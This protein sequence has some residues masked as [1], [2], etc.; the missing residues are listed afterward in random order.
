M[1]NSFEKNMTSKFEKTHHQKNQKPKT[2][3]S[4]EETGG[5]AQ[6]VRASPSKA[7]NPEFK[8]YKP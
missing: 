6:V 7:Q 2:K 3:N 4:T 8:P 5:M 1:T